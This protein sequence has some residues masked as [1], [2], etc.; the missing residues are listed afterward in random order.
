[1]FLACIP[2]LEGLVNV[3]LFTL[4]W[5]LKIAPLKHDQ[6]HDEKYDG[7]A[8]YILFTGVDPF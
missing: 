5:N 1:M 3:I 7:L 8:V 6:Q 4:E 2:R